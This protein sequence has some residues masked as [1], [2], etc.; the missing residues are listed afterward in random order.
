[1][2]ST[3]YQVYGTFSSPSETLQKEL[4]R[5]TEC[6]K[7]S[8]C[9]ENSQLMENF[10]STQID[11]MHPAHQAL[12]QLTAARVETFQGNMSEKVTLCSQARREIFNVFS[13]IPLEQRAEL[14][15]ALSYHFYIALL[16]KIK[17]EAQTLASSQTPEQLAN[18]LKQ[19]VRLVSQFLRKDCVWGKI[20]QEKIEQ[21]G[22]KI[23]SSSAL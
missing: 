17:Q 1:M 14:P 2:F 6:S 19:E 20:A 12:S 9:L 8:R 16:G 10:D 3:N 13:N 4:I 21:L 7:L 22:H 15:T 11:A 23:V 18:Y 5:T